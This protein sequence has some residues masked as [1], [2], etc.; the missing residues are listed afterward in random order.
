ME[1]EVLS[2]VLERV[3]AGNQMVNRQIAADL[4]AEQNR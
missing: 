3:E 1:L 2:V 4:D